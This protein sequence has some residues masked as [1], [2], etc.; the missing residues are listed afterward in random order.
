MRSSGPDRRIFVDTSA[1]YAAVDRRDIDHEAAATVLRQLMESR[2]QLVTTNAVLF[3][4]HGLLV[5]RLNRQAAWETLVALRASQTI[6][7][8]SEQ[9]EARV[10]EIIHQYD[11]KEFSMTD[12]LSFA[13]MERLGLRVVFSLDRHFAQYGWTLL[14]IDEQ[15]EYGV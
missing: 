7:R 2:D 10:E 6:E 14:P 13:V 11:D 1:Y 4:L 12:A 9:D 15:V 5:N 3:E 8:V